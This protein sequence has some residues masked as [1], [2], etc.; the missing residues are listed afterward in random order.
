[1]TEYD[2]ALCSNTDYSFHLSA[3]TIQ[4]KSANYLYLI[5]ITVFTFFT[6][7]PGMLLMTKENRTWWF[8]AIASGRSTTA[9]LFCF[10]YC[11]RD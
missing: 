10:S 1:M 9:S 5:F 3:K 6:R 7:F 4:I 2:T 11:S 8:N